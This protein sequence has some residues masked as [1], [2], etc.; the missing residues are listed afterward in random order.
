MTDDDLIREYAASGEA[1]ALDALVSRHIGR[2]RGMIH[3]I[4]LN[5]ADADDL[6]QEVFLRALRGIGGFRWRSSFSTWLHRI[7]INQARD[8][9]RRKRRNRVDAW[10]ACPERAAPGPHPAEDAAQREESRILREAMNRLPTDLRTAFG[11]V[12][13]D[14]MSPAEAAH[15]QGCFL[16]TVYRRVDAARRALADALKEAQ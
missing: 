10:E 12:A 1:A 3:A 5:D 14:G 15:V 6:T 11:L 13:L 16:S 8:F 4:V 9:L 2:V 7:A